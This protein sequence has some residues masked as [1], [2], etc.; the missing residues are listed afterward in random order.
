MADATTKLSIKDADF[1]LLA[2]EQGDVD[3][4]FN[5]AS[6]W[7]FGSLLDCWGGYENGEVR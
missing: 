6:F 7:L 4:Q 2:A 1:A 5:L 3:A